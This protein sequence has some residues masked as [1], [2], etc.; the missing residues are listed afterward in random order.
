MSYTLLI[1]QFRKAAGMTQEELANKTGIKLSTYRSWEQGIA[2][3]IPLESV[4]R[5]AEVLDCTP[6]DLCGWYIDHPEDRPGGPGESSL[7]HDEAVLLN[8][9]R[10]CTPARQIKAAEAV[11]DQRDLSKEPA[12]DS[13][14]HEEG[15]A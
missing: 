3:K 2:S 1:A 7:T 8:D 6:N 12:A 14:S 15:A 13:Q 10:E 5:I 11:R 4:C 9:Y